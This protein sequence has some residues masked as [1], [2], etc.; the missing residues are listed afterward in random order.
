[1][2][3]TLTLAEIFGTKP[4]KCNKAIPV[5][6]D[7]NGE[8][9][10]GVEIEVEN[11]GGDY[12]YY[13]NLL[14][15]GWEVKEDHSLRASR[16]GVPWEFITVPLQY[17]QMVPA[18]PAFYELTSFTERNFSDRCSI[19][20]HA[21]VTDYTPDNMGALA[22]YYQTL[23]DVLFSF[24]GN[25]RDSNLYCIP[26]SQ[27]RMNH[28]LVTTILAGEFKD[29]VR[30]WQKYTALN[31]LPIRSLGTVEFRQMH[32]TADIPKILSWLG[33][34]NRLMEESK[35]VTLEQAVEEVKKL[36]TEKQYEGFFSR[37]MADVMPFNEYHRDLLDNGVI[38]AKYSMMNFTGEKKP[39]KIIEASWDLPGEE[40][41]ILNVNDGAAQ[42]RLMLE[43]ERMRRNQALAI[44]RTRQRNTEPPVRP[45]PTPR[46]RRAEDLGVVTNTTADAGFQIM[47]GMVGNWRVTD[48][49][50]MVD[51]NEERNA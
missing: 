5:N 26:W 25:Y 42:M 48:E 22:L 39:Q 51:R 38:N 13:T 50:A 27:C 47:P 24:V 46:P 30:Q 18:I 4:P 7:V 45:R 23:E 35:R 8:R 12:E 3:D 1:M 10:Y 33:I 11:C 32:G 36:S 49:F 15:P 37:F 17:N 16:N 20:V 41:P 21:N 44:E 9:F 2:S 6:K 43:I 31:I 28:D 40:A 29:K 19:H 14:R 34:I